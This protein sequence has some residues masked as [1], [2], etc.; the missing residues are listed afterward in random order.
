M[1]FNLL[2]G[3]I[4]GILL[5]SCS[6]QRYSYNPPAFINP[7]LTSKGQTDIGILYSSGPADGTG[8]NEGKNNGLDAHGAYAVSD[9]FS[10]L[11]GYSWRKEKDNYSEV[12]NWNGTSSVSD[13]TVKYK[14]NTIQS[15]G[16]YSLLLPKKKTAIS[17]ALLLGYNTNTL[18]EYGRKDNIG[19]THFFNS[20]GTMLSFQ[21][22]VNFGMQK[23][24]KLSLI[25]RYTF[26]KI[27]SIDTDYTP[28]EMFEAGLLDLD[29]KAL[30]YAALGMSFQYNFK[31]LPWLK[32]NSQFMFSSTG[33][34]SKYMRYA[35][36]S[37][38]SA[39]ASID[40]SSIKGKK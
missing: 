32:I 15:G 36:G 4:I 16:L 40:L 1:K 10:I 18:S 38:Y 28:S 23:N 37:L 11:A 19:Y 12:W 30:F 9:H 35:R 24:L 20:R 2:N 8:A 31:K 7:V 13:A 21:P 34:T 29:Q 14:R 39:G 22:A 27:G 25:N 5:T 33:E 26:E 3:L 6:S 17:L